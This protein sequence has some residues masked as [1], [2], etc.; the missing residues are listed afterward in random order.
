M[1]EFKLDAVKKT[2]KET[3]DKG[4]EETYVYEFVG[5]IGVSE[6]KLSLKSGEDDLLWSVGDTFEF[7]ELTTQQRLEDE[8]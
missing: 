1:A 6:V 8:K 2:T 7:S 4:V 5:Q 3:K